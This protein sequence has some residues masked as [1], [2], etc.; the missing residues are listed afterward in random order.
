M[1]A[2]GK[3]RWFPRH[4]HPVRNGQYECL[5]MLTSSAPNF[6]WTLEWDGKGFLVPC[7]MVVKHWRGLTKA[8]ARKQG[9]NHD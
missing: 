2:K 4:V 1:S 7:P 9:A 8:E 6:L 3:T 5:V